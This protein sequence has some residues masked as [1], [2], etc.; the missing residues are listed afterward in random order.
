M[1]HLDQRA[2]A[3]ALAYNDKVSSPKVAARGRGVMAEAIIQRAR[4]AG[5]YVH[6]SPELVA[7]L[8]RV[9]LDA[10]IP[11]ELYVAVA[12]LLAWL[13][14]IEHPPGA[15]LNPVRPIVSPSTS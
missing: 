3:V 10:H 5:I 15:D 8:M 6:Q 14:G 13:Y 1:P 11:Q 9:D 4:D 2:S 7:L 12:E